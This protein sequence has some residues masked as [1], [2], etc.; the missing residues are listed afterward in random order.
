M[1]RREKER[2][3]GQ[4]DG[5]PKIYRQMY[6]DGEGEAREETEKR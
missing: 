3:K 6:K 5:E 2:K 4:G 1:R